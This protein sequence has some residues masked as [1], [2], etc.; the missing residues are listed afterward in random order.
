MVCLLSF[1]SGGTA[2]AQDICTFRADDGST[3]I[4]EKGES[5]HS[6]RPN[7]CANGAS[8]PCYCNPEAPGQ[9]ECP[10]CWVPSLS[11]ELLCVDNGKSLTY[12]TLKGTLET[13]DCSVS[14]T[15][16]NSFSMDCDPASP[17]T[18]QEDSD[19]SQNTCTIDGVN[20][21]RGQ[22]LGFSYDSGCSGLSFDF[23]CVCNPDL[24]D[25]IECPFCY[26]DIQKSEKPLCLR[27]R[28][29]ATFQDRMGQTRTCSC[30]TES[31]GGTPLSDCS[32][33][34]ESANTCVI[35]IP[36]G[37]VQ[38]FTSGETLHRQIPSRCGPSYPCYC[39][40]T[41]SG[42]LWCPHCIYL[43]SDDSVLCARDGETI[44][45]V[46]LQSKQTETCSCEVPSDP[47]QPPTST[48]TPSFSEQQSGSTATDKSDGNVEEI[49]DD[50]ADNDSWR[51]CE[52]EGN[53]YFEGE[54]VGNSFVT[55]CGSSEEFPC[56]C[57]PDVKPP[58][59]C[60]YCG[61][62]LTKE[63]LLCLKDDQVAKFVDI[64][65]DELTCRC[66]AP[67]GTS[68]PMQNCL[69]PDS[70]VNTCVFRD[71]NGDPFV[72]NA[73]DPV[74]DEL[75]SVSACGPK[76]PCFC[77]PTAENQLSCPFC[78]AVDSG[79]VLICATDGDFVFFE[80][81][82]GSSRQCFCEV[83]DDL[84]LN[85]PALNC[86]GNA[87]PFPSP[88]DSNA[89]EPSLAPS[90]E[91]PSRGETCSVKAPTGETVE[92]ADGD[93]FGDLAGDGVCGNADDWPA[94]C[95]AEGESSSGIN[96]QI[97]YPYCI[98]DNTSSGVPVCARDNDSVS[99]VDESGEEIE[100]ICAFGTPP[101]T[102]CS[103]VTSTPT[104]TPGTPSTTTQR[105]V[106]SGADRI[107]IATFG[108]VV[109]MGLLLF[110]AF[111]MTVT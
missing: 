31:D 110:L 52:L 9:I 18:R 88:N 34:P 71:T 94:F 83:P 72:F 64:D 59:D 84:S 82:D 23:Q 2:R 37:S 26:F 85:E 30:V 96:A 45:H 87:G 50:N 27:D 53:L 48:C 8:F 101:R 51:V 79:G 66:I 4:F 75:L 13:C 99:F 29:I 33:S 36:D 7:R 102:S 73:G 47:Q 92:V 106:N 60:P 22:T 3:I 14:T 12:N 15:D 80:E 54:N 35:E 89:T 49:Q 5:V 76:F 68:R 20:F 67:L 77:D 55:R 41:I 24:P 1:H 58:V 69:I 43:E 11:G 42:Q 91:S 81:E 28:E 46:N 44:T 111:M 19:S 105:P 100:C 97:E 95:N 74:D 103:S 98:F 86:D 21:D 108:N 40:P 39:E 93:P 38:T 25:G 107:T 78:E 90:G 17:Q 57:N 32:L 56:Y 109:S 63:N 70:E 104:T 61:F 62:A 16:F 65:G 6:Y 10:Y